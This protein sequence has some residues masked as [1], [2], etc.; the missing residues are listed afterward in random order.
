MPRPIF[1]LILNALYKGFQMKY[2]LFQKFFGKRVTIKETFSSLL[3][4]ILIFCH[5]CITP[6]T[7]IQSNYEWF[8][9]L[10]YN[11]L[12]WITRWFLVQKLKGW[13]TSILKSRFD[14]TFILTSLHLFFVIE[15]PTN[16]VFC[17]KM[18]NCF[19]IRAK[20]RV[21]AASTTS[22]LRWNRYAELFFVMWIQ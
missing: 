19:S 12:Y 8:L 5:H 6:F 21:I 13:P 15:F 4:R 9:I 7:L 14:F 11:F 3:K 16:I 20:F 10:F 18:K 1:L 17:H 2:H 22:G